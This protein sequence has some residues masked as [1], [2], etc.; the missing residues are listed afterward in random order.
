[1]DWSKTAPPRTMKPPFK[2]M[3]GDPA[4]GDY[5]TGP[6]GEEIR[7]YEVERH[8]LFFSDADAKAMYK[9][10][11]KYIL[12]RVN[13]VNGRAYKDDPTI[14]AWNLINE[15]RCE[16]WLKPANDNCP[17]RM[18]AWLEEMAAFVR[19]QDANHM[20]TV[21]SEGFYGGSTP[22]L[23]VR[24]RAPWDWGLGWGL[25]L[26]L[27]LAVCGWV[28]GART[29]AA[30]HRCSSAR[31]DRLPFPPRPVLLPT[32]QGQNP[33][34][35]GVEM[36][37]D[38]VNNTNI[39]EIDFATVHAWPDNW[40]I[41][42]EKTAGFLEKWVQSHIAAA[43]KNL[44]VQKPVLF[45]EFGKKLDSNQQTAEGIRALRDPIYASTYD[46]VEKAIGNG[47]PIAGSLFWKWA[48][49]V[50]KKQDPRGASLEFGLAQGVGAW[51]W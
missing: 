32:Q 4:P 14:I 33:G 46:N 12:N 26:G 24:A 22:E 30:E 31:P 25:G 48:I 50:F 1:M 15:P 47:Q 39:K 20:I 9:N 27:G 17:Q 7:K 18:Q 13:T 21:G 36:G 19:S 11:A 28:E 40:L 35:W 41:P 37:Q 49:P 43:S 51:G 16:T 34:P 23:L 3:S 45:E 10:N 29:I 38:F 44:K 2:D 8:A 42:Q 6:Q 5:G